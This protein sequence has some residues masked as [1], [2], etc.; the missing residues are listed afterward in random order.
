MVERKIAKVGGAGRRARGLFGV[1]LLGEGSGGLGDESKGVN[2]L[3]G[4]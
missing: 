4:N 3:S 1:Q 2:G